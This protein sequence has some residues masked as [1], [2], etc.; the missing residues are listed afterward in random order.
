MAQQINSD[1]ISS[2][3]VNGKG[4]DVNLFTNSNLPLCDHC[5]AVCDNPH[6]LVCDVEHNDDDLVPFCKNCISELISSNNGNCPIDQHQNPITTPNAYLRKQILKSKV[7][8]IYSSK[9]KQKQLNQNNMQQILETNNGDNYNEE[10]KEGNIAKPELN[11][12]EVCDFTG[13]FKEYINN[14]IL[15]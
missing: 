1:I 2:L 12:E 4:W 3:K 7:I 10:Q 6:E 11:K 8:C 9:Y 14:H 5:N 15:T 13:S